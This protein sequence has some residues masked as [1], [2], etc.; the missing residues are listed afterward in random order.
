MSPALVGKR[1]AL[2]DKRG[3][4][5]F[6]T[7]PFRVICLPTTARSRASCLCLAWRTV[8]WLF[9]L[10]SAAGPLL[11]ACLCGYSLSVP[12]LRGRGCLCFGRHYTRG[13]SESRSSLALVQVVGRGVVLGV[14]CSATLLYRH[15]GGGGAIPSRAPVGRCMRAR[16]HGSS[17]RQQ[18]CASAVAR[19]P[20]SGEPTV[21]QGPARSLRRWQGMRRCAGAL[22]QSICRL[23]GNRLGDRVFRCYLCLQPLD[24]RI[25]WGASL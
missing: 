21:R 18:R 25:R 20:A 12:W 9:G 19:P 8:V 13:F 6:S 16:P 4:D 3:C 2:V 17:N 5:V 1:L 11:V 22:L 24:T 10:A 7:A 15:P 23:R 14:R